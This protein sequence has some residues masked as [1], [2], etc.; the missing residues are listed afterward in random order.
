MFGLSFLSPLFL[1]GLAAAAIPVLIHL[2]H[3][4]TEPVIEFS[5]MRFLRRAPAEQS[6]RRRL[7]ELLLLALRAAAL[8]LL[9]LAFAR[10]YLAPSAAALSAPATLVLLD[11]S[12]S[13]SAPGQLERARARAAE[14]VQGA[15]PGAPVGVLAF[16]ETAEVVAPLGD[17]RVGALTAIRQVQPGAGATRYGAALARAAEIAGGRQARI[18]VLTDL[19]QSGWDAADRGSVPANVTV[20]VEDAGAPASNLA[21]TGLRVDNGEASAA[22]H[23]YA[24][25]PQATQV[26]FTL[27]GRPLEAIAIN[28]AAGGSGE[29]HVA[30]PANATG[31]LAATVADAV[32]YAADNTRYAVLVAGAA[33]LILAVTAS[34]HPSESLYLERA[35][36]VASGRDAFRFRAIGGPAFSG[37]TIDD[38][39][40][41]QAIAVLG[42]RGIEQRGRELLAEYVRRGGGILITAGPDVDPAILRQALQT[43]AQT[44]WRARD[45]A[46]LRFAPDDVRHPI[47]RVFGGVGTLTNVG[48]TRASLVEPDADAEV[49]ARY[50]DGSAAMV[51]EAAG[52][53]RVIVF[54]SD[55]NN[56][57]NDF[58]LQPVFVPFVHET[59]RHLTAAR[60]TQ[61]EYLVGDIRGPAGQTPGVVAL[62][63][64]RVAVNP[65]PRESDPARTTLEAFQESVA[66]LRQA[67]DVAGSPV[68][69]R[70]DDQRLW[71]YALMLV[72]VSLAAESVIGR[73]LG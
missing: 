3:R 73:R 33:P 64:R 12:V 18:V 21:V 55:L 37:Q 62:D 15:V 22:V 42:T 60:E 25:A 14:I 36:A 1:A 63:R 26:S 29:A 43:V 68:E 69:T 24:A 45:A 65:D 46:A 48:F 53:G 19:Q 51:E 4:R 61:S 50:S 34:G 31:A 5:A 10:P 66:D 13:M 6:H 54:G 32:G 39:A 9:A 47:F 20:A 16:A 44:T 59:F 30:L 7:R 52:D 70:E 11:R 8:A 38:L 28:V 58:P 2:F 67:A 49:V 17:D 23:N 71:Q 40:D 35:L 57:W 41:V 56:A 27:E 72:V